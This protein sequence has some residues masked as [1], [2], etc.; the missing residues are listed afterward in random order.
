MGVTIHYRGRLK[1]KESPRNLYI[2][3]K[4]FCD[5]KKW[6]ISQFIEGE[7]TLQFRKHPS[8]KEYRGAVTS[9]IIKPH[10]HCEPVAFHITRD[11]YFEDRCKTQFAPLE[12]HLGVVEL[13]ESLRKRLGELVVEDEGHYWE[14]RSRERLEKQIM[15]CYEEILR[16]KEEDPAYYG[17]VKEPDGRITD[18]SKG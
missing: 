16:M 13:L 9:F 11:G 8:Q 1:P 17:P 14:T 4:L 6:P 2:L 18:L 15:A 3:A 10:E 5:G 7:E 12:V